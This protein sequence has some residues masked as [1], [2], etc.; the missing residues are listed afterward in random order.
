MLLHPTDGFI[1]EYLA[2]WPKSMTI[3]R[4]PVSK[5]QVEIIIIV[6]KITRTADRWGPGNGTGFVIET[7]IPYVCQ[8]IIRISGHACKMVF[9]R[10]GIFSKEK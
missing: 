6:P 4:F 3:I 2:E 9:G 10:K 7:M 1:H 5:I 8:V